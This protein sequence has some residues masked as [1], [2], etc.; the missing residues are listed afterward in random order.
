MTVSMF[1]LVLY[2]EETF[3]KIEELL[4]SIMCL[5]ILCP[6]LPV[7]D[8]TVFGTSFLYVSES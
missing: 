8:L 7:H 2:G 1:S 6:V 3:T 5:R 4:L